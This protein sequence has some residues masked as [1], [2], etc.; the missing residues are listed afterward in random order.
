MARQ[1]NIDKLIGA[2]YKAPA[3]V[4]AAVRLL[5]LLLLLL[6]PLAAAS[7]FLGSQ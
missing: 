6:L 5:L 7:R 2:L 1:V 3:A 4:A